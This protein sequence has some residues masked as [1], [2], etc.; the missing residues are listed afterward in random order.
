MGKKILMFTQST[1]G[2]MISEGDFEKKKNI[3]YFPIYR[4]EPKH[5]SGLS[6]GI[7]IGLEMCLYNQEFI[8]V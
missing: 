3:T 7:I 4:S 1:K 8:T 5:L 6:L 2:K